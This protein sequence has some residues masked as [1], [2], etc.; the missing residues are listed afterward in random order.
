MATARFTALVLSALAAAAAL[1]PTTG[2]TTA[3]VTF[4]PVPAGPPRLLGVTIV[5]N[6]A[7]PPAGRVLIS[8]VA[9]GSLGERLGLQA[10]DVIDQVDGRA[11][12]TLPDVVAA[13]RDPRPLTMRLTRDGQPVTV[14]E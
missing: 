10:G 11:M 1:P 2:P 5:N 14:A 4:T 6:P 13:V 3:P 9:A 12:A 7:P 8:T